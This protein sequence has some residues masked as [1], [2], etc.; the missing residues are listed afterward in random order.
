MNFK[1][2]AFTGFVATATLVAAAAFVTTSRGAQTF[3][4]YGSNEGVCSEQGWL[5]ESDQGHTISIKSDGTFFMGDANE[6]YTGNWTK[7]NSETLRVGDGTY[8]GTFDF[9]PR[10]S[11][12]SFRF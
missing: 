6:E 1:A 3:V 2:L 12:G 7:I 8:E 11:D 4:D 9:S 10:C 5:F